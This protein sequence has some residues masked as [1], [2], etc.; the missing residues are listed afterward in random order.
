MVARVGLRDELRR[1]IFVF[2]AVC[3][4]FEA[5]LTEFDG[6]RDHVHLS[7]HS[8]AVQPI[9]KYSRLDHC[10]VAPYIAAINDGALRS[11]R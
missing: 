8:E 7:I 4:D 2:R 9:S 3:N 5:D 11:I 1:R 6:E 10:A